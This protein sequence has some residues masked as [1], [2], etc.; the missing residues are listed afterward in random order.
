MNWRLAL[1]LTLLAA[2]GPLAMS[3]LALPAL[4]DPAALPV[5]LETLQIVSAVQ[6]IGLA[7][8]A[9]VLGTWLAHRVGLRAPASA[10]LLGRESAIDALR[11]QLLPGLLGGLAGAGI[12]LAF[13][14]VRPAALAA[15]TD[16]S[17]LP[18]AARVLYG[19]VTEEILIRWGLMSC[20]VWG[21]WRLFQHGRGAVST[22]WMLLG[23]VLS[24]LVFG[25][26]HL[27]VVATAVG[28]LP[29]SAAAYVTLA[30]AAFG[31][32]AGYLF[33]RHG[34]EAAIIAHVAA[35]LLAWVLGG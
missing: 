35:H 28:P 13:H 22:T 24:A 34:L 32:V 12:V 26:A 8:L 15:G 27:P 4:I 11:P 17:I 23:I 3:W 33:W 20:I 19:G 16:P 5:P 10:A 29:A 14:A 1:L 31:L 25:L 9:A 7:A 6:G 2:P 18:I 21:A 30:N